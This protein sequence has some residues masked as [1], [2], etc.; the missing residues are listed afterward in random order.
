TDAENAAIAVEAD[1][2]LVADLARVVG[3]HQVL[4]PALGPLHGPSE[5]HGGE[6]HEDVLRIELAAH[7]ETS[8]HIHLGEAQGAERNPEDRRED[9]AVD[10]NA[11][12]RAD[13]V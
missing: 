13:Q 9:R 5:L 11:F 4:S 8:A 6:R 7:A 12:G 2:D 10:V 1:L 3:R